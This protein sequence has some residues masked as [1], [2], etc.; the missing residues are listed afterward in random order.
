MN[1]VITDDEEIHEL[2]TKRVFKEIEVDIT[3]DIYRK[4]CLGR[5]DISAFKDLFEIYKVKNQDLD[6][7]TAHKSL[8]YQDLIQGNLKVYP[9]VI[10]L[11]KN[12]YQYYTLALTSSSTFEEVHTVVNE[13]GIANLFQVIVTSRDVK[14]GKPHPEPYFLTAKELN[15]RCEECLVIEDSG[16][17]VLAAKSAGMKCVAIPNTEIR[18][19]LVKADQI[20]ETY[21]SL[22]NTFIRNI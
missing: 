7:L 19:N 16:N 8:I 12:L 22:T 1:G 21:S 17:G 6:S 15:V 20:I 13:L 18:A 5:T 11:I 9:G 4:Y 10:S 2:A 3:S 14:H